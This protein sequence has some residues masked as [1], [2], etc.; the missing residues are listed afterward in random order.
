MTLCGRFF[1]YKYVEGPLI[2]RRRGFCKQHY[3]GNMVT[4]ILATPTLF[5]YVAYFHLD[6]SYVIF[7]LWV[8]LYFCICES[9]RSRT[10]TTSMCSPECPK[11]RHLVIGVGGEGVTLAQ[12]ASHLTLRHS[13]RP[14]TSDL[15]RGMCPSTTSPRIPHYLVE[16]PRSLLC[17]EQWLT[18]NRCHTV[19]HMRHLLCAGPNGALCCWRQ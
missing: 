11:G 6:I 13:I 1:S 15:P 12:G 5:L 7:F 9:K 19:Q 18:G 3:I 8:I 2:N 4:L 10:T 17:L 14:P 16:D